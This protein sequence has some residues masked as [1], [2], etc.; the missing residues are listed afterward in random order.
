EGNVKKEFEDTEPIE[1]RGLRNAG[2]VGLVYI[3]FFVLVIFLPDSPLR[4]EEGGMIPSP[5][6]TGIVPIIML[7]FITIGVAY[8]ITTKKI[9]N[10]RSI[11]KLMGEAM[12]DMS[13]F[14]VLIFAA[15][16]F[17]AYFECTIIGSCLSLFIYCF[18]F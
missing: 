10:M 12:K 11:A 16:Q 14:I 8:G 18:L 9:E 1:K 6:L 3:L 13:G 15:S 2:I 5:F 17:I 4:N 7:F